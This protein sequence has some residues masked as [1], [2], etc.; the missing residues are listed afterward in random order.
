V[1]FFAHVD[2][3][4]RDVAGEA[5]QTLPERN[6]PGVALNGLVVETLLDALAEMEQP[7]TP[8]TLAAALGEY[9]RNGSTLFHAGERQAGGGAVIAI[10]K[11]DQGKFELR[12]PDEWL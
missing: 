1:F 7:P 5:A 8:T 9:R 4:Q 11:P 3:L 6:V 2:P 10:P 12:L